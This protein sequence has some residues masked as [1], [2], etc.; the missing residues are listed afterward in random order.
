MGF[1]VYITDQCEEDSEKYGLTKNV[2][3]LKER[4]L[5]EQRTDSLFDNFPPPY[6]K[7]RFERQQRLIAATRYI[8]IDSESHVVVCFYRILIR[9]GDEY[10]KGFLK[11]P[12]KWG[13]E[14]LQPLV[15]DE[16]LKLW[17]RDN[18][19][20]PAQEKPQPDQFEKSFLW[21]ILSTRS[22]S[23]RAEMIYES[24]DWIKAIKDTKLSRRLIN[25]PDTILDICTGEETEKTFWQLD[26]EVLIMA[27]IF[28]EKGRVFLIAPVWKLQQNRIE[29]L[30]ENYSEILQS[31]CNFDDEGLARK[32]GRAYPYEL[33]LNKDLWI[34]A[35]EDEAAN[36][37]LSAEEATLLEDVHRYDA[38]HTHDTGLPLFI[39][40]RAGSGKST[41]L[42]YLFADYL[43]HY[44]FQH[45]STDRKGPLYLTCSPELLERSKKSI[46]SLVALNP[47]NANRQAD[48]DGKSINDA[49][50][51]SALEFHAFLYSLLTEEEKKNKFPRISGVDPLKEGNNR[52]DYALFF[53]M[54]EKSF[55]QNPDFKKY[56]PE[57]AWHIIRTYIKGMS[58]DDPL[59]ADDY[60]EL[61]N[62]EKS[63]SHETFEGVYNTVWKKYKGECDKKRLW[64]DQ[65]LARFLLMEE[66]ISG[67]YVGI[68]CDEAQDFTRIELEILLRLSVFSERKLAS[69][70]ITRVP[71]VF[72]GD[73]FQTLNPTGFR[74]EAVKATF[75]QKFIASIDPSRQTGKTDINYR[76][77]HYNYRS[78][79]NIVKF[80]NSIQ[81]LRRFLFR[82]SGIKPQIPW[83]HGDPGAPP[84]WYNWDE[85]HNLK[86]NIEKNQ[87][88][89]III[90][91]R[92]GDEVDFINNDPRLKAWIPLDES[93][94]PRNVLSAIRAKGLEFDRVALYGFGNLAPTGL[95]PEQKPQKG[96]ELSPEWILPREYFINR[97]YVAASRGKKQ[98]FVLDS[99]EGYQHLWEIFEE[100]RFNAIVNSFSIEE[101]KSWQDN[102]GGMLLPGTDDAWQQNRGDLRENA[103]KY[104]V[105]GK[106]RKDPYLLRAAAII[107]EGLGDKQKA[108]LCRAIAFNYE[109]NF[110]KAGDF[111]N[112]NGDSASAL[113]MYWTGEHFSK[114]TDLASNYPDIQRSIEYRFVDALQKKNLAQI[115][116]IFKDIAELLREQNTRRRVTKT[117]L[118][119]KNV[120]KKLL[121]LV[122]KIEPPYDTNINW[123][124]LC[125]VSVDLE[126]QGYINSD[127]LAFL[128]F[129]TGN[130][131]KTIQLLDQAKKTDRK[132]YRQA[133]TQLLFERIKTD[134]RYLIS[135]EEQKLLAQYYRE[136]GN[137]V[138][139]AKYYAMH[140]GVGDIENIIDEAI[141]NKQQSIPLLV[142]LLLK[143]YTSCEEWQK[144]IQYLDG[145]QLT[146]GQI[147]TP[148]KPSAS[149]VWDLRKMI[150]ITLAS[151]GD[152]HNSGLEIIQ[153][154][155]RV[156]QKWVQKPDSWQHLHP[157]LVGAVLERVALDIECLK[158]YEGIYGNDSFRKNIL[159][160]AKKR[161]LACKLRQIKREEEQSKT[162]KQAQKHRD[163]LLKNKTQWEISHPEQEP[164]LPD[165]EYI[166]LK[167]NVFYEVEDE[168]ETLGDE[169]ASTDEAEG[170]ITESM[171]DL[172][173]TYDR[174]TGRM[175]VQKGEFDSISIHAGKK[176]CVSVD[177]MIN[178]VD[179]IHT[180]AD[181]ELQCDFSQL[182][183]TGQFLLRVGNAIKSF[184]IEG[185]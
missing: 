71:F 43:R 184:T 44:L 118:T 102:L 140:H 87:D 32:S 122:E 103:S 22:S 104:E 148:W 69:E 96:Q 164:E 128:Y 110:E 85:Q 13:E 9:G 35:E 60:Q 26:A 163:E 15:L 177:V 181:W 54:W 144:L 115:A 172:T 59:D 161:W 70:E 64:D 86:D 24:P 39:N 53:R 14:N 130:F 77:L 16:S 101:Q 52:V 80:T 82:Q 179:D 2:Q 48:L 37:A 105:E 127:Q 135:I 124:Q 150:L 10:A 167:E 88:V 57:L 185:D 76:E 49:V 46:S 51:T 114:I 1:Y 178:T 89:V 149:E 11:N 25:F 173:I 169:L 171:G 6:L 98:M 121:D 113:E 61:D 27:R 99:R 139:A 23:R 73:P 132:F 183:N 165:L 78:T 153:K 180:V 31:G 7:K 56:T 147:K 92:E 160:N 174:K 83:Q 93:G 66:R 68:F 30:R 21:E 55:A 155:S 120:I 38:E 109:G 182:E 162:Q 157:I 143:V 4:L 154:I 137:Y 20:P 106:A 168:R 111:Y 50:K 116:I 5:K 175:K 75:F 108:T 133:K 90:P 159:T 94:V 40:G 142:S 8:T 17:M 146:T 151:S 79:P 63:V 138:E 45:D 125:D 97:L 34:S 62:R 119:W 95:L 107:Y 12:S 166:D 100:V 134:T 152:L 136:Q 33:L 84:C 36:L 19:P 141:R 123:L 126:N 131:E 58:T 42:Q 47:E 112:I 117:I 81:A 67:D 41:V 74:W 170:T 145:E 176:S 18:A 156:V 72:A 28:P 129:R 65:D 3:K 29:E 91:C 158:Y